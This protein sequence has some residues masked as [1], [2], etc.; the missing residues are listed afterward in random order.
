MS[1]FMQYRR[2]QIAELRPWQPGDDMSRVS[3]S[4][5]D[6]ESGSPKA[7]DM[8]ARNPKNHDDMW[9]IAAAYFADNFEPALAAAPE[10]GAVTEAMRE[11]GWL[12]ERKYP[13]NSIGTTEPRWYAERPNGDHWWTPVPNDAKRF[14][15]RAEA[16]AYPAYQMIA[17]DPSIS[18]TEHVWINE[19]FSWSHGRA[20]L[21]TAERK[22]EEARKALEPFAQIA[23]DVADNHPGCDH[24]SFE[25]ALLA[26]TVT[27]APFRRARRTIEAAAALAAAP[28][29]VAGAYAIVE[30]DDDMFITQPH[31]QWGSLCIA[32]RPKLMSND[33]WRPLAQRIVAA[34][35]AAPEG[36]G[37]AK[38]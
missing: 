15:S 21:E 16:E 23:K 19:G 1:V 3:V 38:S 11:T 8:I 13:V 37:G 7:G 4:A 12:I 34:L 14:A 24:D 35:A 9:L 17:S 31:W 18:I 20:A 32:R 5:P 27:L 25:F 2:K 10:A 28:E 6:K 33:Q 30:R 29:G 26:Y 36:S 22:L